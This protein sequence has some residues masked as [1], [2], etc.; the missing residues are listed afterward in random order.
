MEEMAVICDDLASANLQAWELG[1]E[2]MDKPGGPDWEE[3][4]NLLQRALCW[5]G[6]AE[7][8]R[9]KAQRQLA[10]VVDGRRVKGKHRAERN[11]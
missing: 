10:S 7:S 3:V 2:A 11:G 8:L 5:H 1:R 4:D 9:G 6:A